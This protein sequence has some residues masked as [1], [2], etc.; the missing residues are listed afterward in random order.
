VIATLPGAGSLTL[1]GNPVSALDEID[2]VD[3]DELAFTPAAGVSGQPYTSFTFQVRDDG[4]TA[5]GGVD[6]DA[7]ANTMT[8]DVTDI[9]DAPAGTSNTLTV[10]EDGEITFTAASFGFTDPNDTP[11]NALDAIVIAT[12]PGAGSLTLSGNPVTAL[13]EIDVADVNAGNLK[14]T[15]VAN[16]NGTGYAAFTFQVRDDGG[17]VNGGADLDPSANTMTIDVTSVN[18][19]PAGADKSF[20]VS[21]NTVI[22]FAPADFGFTDPNDSPAN[23]TNGIRVTTLPS[24]GTL[25]RNGN[26]VT[27]GQTITHGQINS[28]QLEFT[29]V[30]GASGTPY[31]S[32]TFQV[33]DNGGT[34]DG[35]VDED[36]SPNTI[37]INVNP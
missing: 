34:L 25:T 26:A 14:F 22:V 29:P 5:N 6:L 36:Q 31:T 18:D 32:F 3:I 12:L 19:A 16:A 30:T 15:P 11:A 20:T 1:S 21:L 23:I 4:G 28:G 10:L 27:V 9:N 13:D 24:A 7:S 33:R 37:T 2:V 35:G 8:I 17:T